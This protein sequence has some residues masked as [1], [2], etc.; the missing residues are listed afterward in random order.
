MDNF[1][2]WAL[3]P[4]AHGALFQEIMMSAQV[5]AHVPS[6]G[7]PGCDQG[8]WHTGDTVA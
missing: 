8:L 6:A 4:K 2:S 5:V 1:L 3:S 7:S